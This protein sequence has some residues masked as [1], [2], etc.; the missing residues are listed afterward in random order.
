MLPAAARL[1]ARPAGAAL[2]L[3]APA[4]RPPHARR[5]LASAA[6]GAGGGQPAGAEVQHMSVNELAELLANP[7]LCDECQ[8]IDVREQGEWA[9][10]RLPRFKLLPLSEAGEW[11]PTIDETLDP[12][13]ETVVLCHHG[14]RSMSAAQFLVSR[15]FSNVKNVTGGIAAYSGID[16]SVPQY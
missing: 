2:R 15:G 3:A 13:R 5:G 7:L 8:F 4:A 9:T 16:P 6:G 11:A 14:M 1:A 12:A 10:A